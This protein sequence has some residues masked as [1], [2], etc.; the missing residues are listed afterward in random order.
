LGFLGGISI[1]ILAARIGQMYPRA[2]PSKLL[3]AFFVLYNS[4]KWSGHTLHSSEIICPLSPFFARLL[5]LSVVSPAGQCP[6][7]SLQRPKTR[8]TLKPESQTRARPMP[9]GLVDILPN[10]CDL[11]YPVWMCGQTE[12][13]DKR[14]EMPIITPTYPCQN[15]TANVSKSTL[16]I[17][18]EEFARGRD[19]CK[20]V[21]AGTATW[22]ELFEP[23]DAI[24]KYPNLLQV[25][26]GDTLSS[27]KFLNP[28]T[29]VP[30]NQ[31]PGISCDIRSFLCP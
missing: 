17:M 28:A 2:L 8:K 29:S 26:V 3:S 18:Q 12:M 13:M 4:W 31:K 5:R 15:A 16:K 1:E 9:V 23:L 21:E 11:G 14:H 27:H 7:N 24:S 30:V 10:S 20:R 25:Q 19:V 6:W 22:S